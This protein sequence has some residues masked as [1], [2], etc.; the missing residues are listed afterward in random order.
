MR[1]VAAVVDVFS[2]LGVW[3]ALWIIIIIGLMIVE[4]PFKTGGDV[5]SPP[6]DVERLRSQLLITFP[7]WFAW[8]FFILPTLVG[9]QTIGKNE[10]GIKAIRSTGRPPGFRYAFL[11]ETIK[12]GPFTLLLG[13]SW[14]IGEPRLLGLVGVLFLLGFL[15]T[16]RDSK[17]QGWHDKIAGTYVIRTQPRPAAASEESGLVTKVDEANTAEG[18]P[19]IPL[20]Q[21]AGFDNYRDLLSWTKARRPAK[22]RKIDDQSVRGVNKSRIFDLYEVELGF[23]FLESMELY[24]QLLSRGLVI[25]RYR[26]ARSEWGLYW[27]VNIVTGL[28]GSWDLSGPAGQ[29][30]ICTTYVSQPDEG[31]K[32]P[33]RRRRRGRAR[34]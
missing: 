12:L 5:P 24:S 7:L 30:Y 18:H 3:I 16:A 27:L 26:T 6:T 8:P 9:G 21:R 33:K 23:R 2:I 1:L 13:V 20:L 22:R 32:K 15:T 4:G 17:R 25:E 10:L 19:N 31:G 29:E 28:F 14:V 34:R 11:R